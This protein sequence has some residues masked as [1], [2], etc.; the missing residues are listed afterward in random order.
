[1]P[2]RDRELVS[3]SPTLAGLQELS[4]PALVAMLLASVVAVLDGL[5]SSELGIIGLLAVPPVIAA[6]SSSLPETAVV[7]AFCVI[8][9]LLSI[10]WSQGIDSGQRLVALTTVAAGALAGL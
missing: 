7:A 1:M 9:A 8:L 4:G 10:I 5:A 3:H 2:L 6:M